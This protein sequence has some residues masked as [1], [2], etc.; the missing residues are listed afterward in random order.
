M[1][2]ADPTH[3]IPPA[4]QPARI[5]ALEAERRQSVR[6]LRGHDTT[7]AHRRVTDNRQS[8]DDDLRREVRATGSRTTT[9]S[10]YATP[11]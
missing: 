8:H 11:I 9:P 4:S 2:D 1:D 3:P 10:A 6:E 7:A 5:D